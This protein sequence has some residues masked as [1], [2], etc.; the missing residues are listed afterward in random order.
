[1]TYQSTTSTS[2]LDAVIYNKA[3]SL[4]R[5]KITKYGNMYLDNELAFVNWGGSQATFRI[6]K[7]D[8]LTI[9]RLN[10][11]LARYHFALKLVSTPAEQ[12]V[13]LT[14]A[15]KSLK[16]LVSDK[17]YLVSDLVKQFAWVTF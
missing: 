2:V 9:V 14:R 13:I 6:A 8:S 15:G 3:A 16:F 11:L 10:T 5:T 1:M 17:S 12:A 4:Y 7:L